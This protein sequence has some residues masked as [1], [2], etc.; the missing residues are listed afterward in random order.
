MSKKNFFI[1]VFL[2][3]I[4]SL[5][6]A[7]FYS[8]RI[9]PITYPRSKTPQKWEKATHVSTKIKN[10]YKL[11]ID[12][13]EYK[14]KQTFEFRITPNNLSSQII[15]RNYEPILNETA[16][17]FMSSM[18]KNSEYQLLKR[19]KIRDYFM[20][21]NLDYAYSGKHAHTFEFSCNKKQKNKKRIYNQDI[22]NKWK[23]VSKQWDEYKGFSFRIEEKK[24]KE[25]KYLTR[26]KIEDFHKKLTDYKRKKL[27]EEFFSKQIIKNCS[28]RYN[29]NRIY[30]KPTLDV[31]FLGGEYKT[32]ARKGVYEYRY[33]CLGRE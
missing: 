26:L 7:C 8:R 27:L 28:F 14:E 4:T 5:L 1:A 2:F 10:G 17:E 30:S 6:S 12:L 29:V 20:L 32:T 3:S 21:A 22:Y 11:K 15:N 23:N 19:E 25:D 9:K 18:C 13:L 24:I 16:H 31:V 33:D